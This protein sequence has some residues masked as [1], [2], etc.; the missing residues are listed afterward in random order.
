[1]FDTASGKK[2]QQRYIR[3]LYY[4]TRK[5][6]D[7]DRLSL[8]QTD[9]AVKY[10]DVYAPFDYLDADFI[11][12]ISYEGA[13]KPTAFVL[14]MIY[15]ERIR[16]ANKSYFDNSD[17]ADLLSSSLLCAMKYLYDEGEEDHAYND[18]WAASCSKSVDYVTEKEFEF[19]DKIEWRL[20]VKPWEF[21]RALQCMEFCIAIREGLKRNFFTYTDLFVV[22]GSST[23]MKNVKEILRGLATAV[24]LSGIIY[25]SAVLAVHF[26]LSRHIPI[27]TSMQNH[28]RITSTTAEKLSI[29]AIMMKRP[30]P[31]IKMVMTINGSICQEMGPNWSMISKQNI[32]HIVPII[33]KL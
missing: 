30:C 33:V 28:N 12:H 31:M 26:A 16:L 15:L 10:F 22:F 11:N 29:P 2:L 17:P 24:I 23:T 32:S 1:M 5:W 21:E 3:T 13:V 18:E 19:L 7:L 25:L 27:G 9:F 20:Y 4:G 14:A 6:D 8:A